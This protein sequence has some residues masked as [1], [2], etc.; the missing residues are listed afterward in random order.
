MKYPRY[1]FKSEVASIMRASTKTVDRR[2]KSGKLKAS[3]EGGRVVV[4]ELDLEEYLA[5]LKPKGPRR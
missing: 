4:R 1:L 5:S 3:R 2:I